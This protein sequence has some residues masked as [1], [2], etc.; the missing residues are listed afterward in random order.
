MK[1]IHV[2]LLMLS[3][4]ALAEEIQYPPI[5]YDAPEPPL[6]K[7]AWYKSAP[8]KDPMNLMEVCKS[9]RLLVAEAKQKEFFATHKRCTS[10][11]YVKLN[12][13]CTAKVNV[14]T[15]KPKTK[16]KS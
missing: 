7:Y 13:S 11:K 10:W 12:D 5:E 9:K 15:S 1:I 6:S 8:C 4:N 2:G 14:V 3:M 16:I